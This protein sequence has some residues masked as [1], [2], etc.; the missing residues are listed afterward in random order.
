MTTA[1]LSLLCVVAGA[2]L[3][4]IFTRV[5]ENQR[6]YRTLRTQSYMD[7]LKCVSELAQ[8][9][10]QP[11][12][13]ETQEILARGADAKAR[14]CL[15]GS[16]AVVQAFSEFEK[17]GGVLKTKG[18]QMCFCRMVLTMRNDSGGQAGANL[19]DLGKLLLGNHDISA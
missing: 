14:I 9:V 7:Y 12:A 16:T 18:Q 19:D 5:L 1:L 3:Q 10:V 6:H 15:Y 11:Q 17:L 2:S 4:Y 8:L 13:R